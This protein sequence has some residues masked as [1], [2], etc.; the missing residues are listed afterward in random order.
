M[1]NKKN[2][3]A[4]LG[5]H[6]LVHTEAGCYSFQT[7]G[8]STINMAQPS[9]L[10]MYNSSYRAIPLKVGEFNIVPAGDTNYFPFEL[11]EILDDAN[12]L[13]GA[14]DKQ[15]GL[16]WGQGPAL[17]TE[18]YEDRK[19]IKDWKED[20]EVQAWLESWDYIRYL[21]ISAINFRHLS[22][23]F[24]K[25]I[26]NKG[27]RVGQSA[28]INELEYISPVHGRLEW[29]D[30]KGKINRIIVGDWVQPWKYGLT[31]Y[32]VF[33]WKN[34]FA[35]PIAAS[36]EDQYSFGLDN[37]YARSA[38]YGSLNWIKLSS[39]LAKLLTN[40]NLNSAAIKY[41]IEVP[42]Q[43]WMDQQIKLENKCL[44]EGI[45]YT[46]AMLQKLKS[47]TFAKVAEVLSG[48]EN[49][50]KFLTTDILFDEAGGEFI[51]WKVTPLDQKVKDYIDAQINIS[52]RA[53]FEI[54]SGIGLDPALG[55]ISAEGN[56]SG[57][58]EKLYAFKLYM[59]TSNDIP[60]YIVCKH[61]NHAIKAN[62]PNKNIKIG[63]YHDTVM[64][65]EQVN[66]ANRMKNN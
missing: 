43:Y 60:E 62:F 64:V 41:H 65:E 63:F 37:R 28:R 40:F 50:G 21:M 12:L 48:I 23:Y 39:S 6:H 49:V 15:L 35:N 24:S 2:S 18:I 54:T 22:Y 32:P 13:P 46:D 7:V 36:Y 58:S 25:F 53:A 61:L 26:R 29:P 8:A 27:P 59:K 66:P 38:F 1:N 17:Y 14:L 30:E 42:A 52:K 11:R 9:V 5:D 33:D 19:K 55:N 16:L 45:E 31:P 34:P 51:G 47:D 44:N 3:I 10:P 57:G 4:S 56:L 20:K